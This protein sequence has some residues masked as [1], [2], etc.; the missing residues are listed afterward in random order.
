MK[1][2]KK[3]LYLCSIV[4]VII[5]MFIITQQKQAHISIDDTIEIFEDLTKNEFNYNSIF[6]NT[7]LN[8]FK[9][10]HEKYNVKVS[11]YCFYQQNEFSLKQCTDKFK[12]EFEKNSDWLRFGFHSYDSGTD[13]TKLDKEKAKEQYEEFIKELKRIVSSKSITRVVRL[14]RFRAKKDTIYAF[15]QTEFGIKGLLGA[16]TIDRDNYYLSDSQNNELFEKGS[17]Y[18]EELKVKIHTTD[19]RIENINDIEVTLERNLNDKFLVIFTHEW[20]LNEDDMKNKL[21][22]ICEILQK[23]KIKFSI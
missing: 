13:Y 11:F 14:D 9:K 19:I 7:T 2:H 21:I 17:Y 5:L 18:D 6:D 1:N 4:I 20:L 8:F 16:D 12:D 10:L 3:Y 23:N 15:S 22:E